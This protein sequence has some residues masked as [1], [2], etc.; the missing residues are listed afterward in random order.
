MPG[1][2]QQITVPYPTAE[3]V[4]RL[5]RVFCLDA[6]ISL[7][8]DLLADTSNY[9]FPILQSAYEY[10]QQE[11]INHG[12][13]A[14]TKETIL[15]NVAPVPSALQGPG[16]QVSIGHDNYFDGQQPQNA[17][18]LPHDLIT[19][20]RLWERPA[21]SIQRFVEMKPALDG[22][23]SLP[24]ST[25]LRQWEWREDRIY[26]IG[27]TQANDLRCRY[28]SYFPALTKAVDPVKIFQG[29]NAI[30]YDSA[31]KFAGPRAGE[32]QSYF[33]GERDKAIQ[34]LVTRIARK[35][36]RRNSRP[37]PYGMMCRSRD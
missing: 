2:G 23:D 13:E 24:Q 34:Q 30:A 19:P 12:Y 6:G 25:F 10:V 9:T 28:K 29:G 36:Q 7:D 31:I 8:G 14:P 22:L 4:L 11:L 37:Q 5:T 33:T 3:Q 21:G 20:L 18:L 16:T 26:L 32:A 1:I 15:L 17:P 27:S 35:N